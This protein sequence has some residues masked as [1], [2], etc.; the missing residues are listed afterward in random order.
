LLA[1]VRA[2]DAAATEQLLPL[3]YDEL[4]RLAR[5][6]PATENPAHTLQPTALV[7]SLIVRR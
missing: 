2:G 1:R 4:R 5:P 7:H 6:L 3:V